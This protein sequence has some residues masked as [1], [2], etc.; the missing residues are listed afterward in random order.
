MSHIKV[1]ECSGEQVTRRPPPDSP[2]HDPCRVAR[3]VSLLLSLQRRG[4]DDPEVSFEH[5]RQ[6][7]NATVRVAVSSNSPTHGCVTTVGNVD[8]N[9]PMQGPLHRLVEASLK[10][11]LVIGRLDEMPFLQ[12][13]RLCETGGLEHRR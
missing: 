13:V 10:D 12:V 3:P 5:Y 4:D 11:V 9:V 8:R 6:Q 2:K 7:M 1:P